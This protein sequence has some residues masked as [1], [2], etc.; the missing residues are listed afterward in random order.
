LIFGRDLALSCSAFWIRYASLPPPVST[1]H[2]ELIQKTLRR[3][4][5]PATPSAEVKPTQI[6]K[7]NTALQLAL[8]GVTTVS[9]LLP[10]ISLF[11][12]GLQWTVAGTTV[13]S[14]LSYLGARGFRYVK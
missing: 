14:G 11:L 10:D 4:F 3:Y 5:S 7:I 6:S 9:P 8:M 12:L 1:D 13:W 2:A